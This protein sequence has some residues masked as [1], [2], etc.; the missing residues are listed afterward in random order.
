MVNERKSAKRFLHHVC[1]Y[2]FGNDKIQTE[3]NPFGLRPQTG[4][5]HFGRAI[6]KCERDRWCCLSSL[7][8][9]VAFLCFSVIR[10]VCIVYKR[11]QRTEK[12]ECVCCCFVLLFSLFFFF[13]QK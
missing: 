10:A 9:A 13:F 1:A 2:T 5:K 6:I 11:D 3:K 12:A 7:A 4:I 8:F